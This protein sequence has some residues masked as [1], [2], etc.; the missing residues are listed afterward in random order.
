MSSRPAELSLAYLCQLLRDEGLLSEEQVRELR[1][2]EP[3]LRQKLAKEHASTTQRYRVSPV[4]VVL[5]LDLTMADGRRLT[6]DRVA[7]VLAKET[8][9]PYTNLDPLKLYDKL[10]TETISRA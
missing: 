8:T 9:L 3:Y 10:V 4:E 7:E 6:E 1:I 2:R 5:A